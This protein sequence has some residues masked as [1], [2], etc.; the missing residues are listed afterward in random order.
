MLSLVL[1]FFLIHVAIYLINTVGATTIDNLLWIFYLKL[2]TSTSRQG[3]EAARLKREA[4]ELKRDMN[5]TSSQD[6]F[7][8]WAK[9]RRRHDKT[10]EEYESANK[11]LSSQ[12]SSFDWAIKIAR[13]V[14]T[15]GLKLFLQFRYNSTPVFVLPPGWFPYFVEWGLSFPK[16]PM[17]AVSVQVWSSVCGVAVRVLAEIVSTVLLWVGSR[18]QQ[19]RAIPVEA[20]T[21]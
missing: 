7:A 16:A 11:A 4:L 14:S 15:S 10:Y 6:E 2:P 17:G 9:L 20:K 13:W 19:R 3:R 1:T 12:K 21:Q 5:N 8:K 18:I